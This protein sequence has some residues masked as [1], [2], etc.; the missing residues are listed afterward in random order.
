MWWRL[1]RSDWDAGKPEGNRR[2]FH[3]RVRRGPPPG[4]LAYSD[5]LAVG[6]CQVT[7]R[8][9]LPTLGRSRALVAVDTTPVWSLSCFY[10]KAGWR[11]RG[12]MTALV[13][14]AV[15]HARAAGAPALE[16]YPWETAERQSSTTVYTGLAAVFRQAGFVEVARRVAHRP[17]MRHDLQ[18]ARGAGGFAMN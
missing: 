6:W 15:D 7:P 17:I 16:A 2:A 5:G 18:P 10:I 3:A 14:A 1:K 13:A 11:R 4:L 12:V 8:A 9:E